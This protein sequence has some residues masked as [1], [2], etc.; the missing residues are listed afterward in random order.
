MFLFQFIQKD[1]KKHFLKVNS[2]IDI[3]YIYFITKKKIDNYNNLILIN[4]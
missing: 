1:K 3:N 4:I 2:H